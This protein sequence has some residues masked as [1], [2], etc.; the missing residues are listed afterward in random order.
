MC[1]EQPR[2]ARAMAAARPFGPEPTTTASSGELIP[3]LYGLELNVRGDRVRVRVGQPIKDVRDVQR[4][5]GGEETPDR[6]EGV[7]EHELCRQGRQGDG[8]PECSECMI[9][10]DQ[11]RHRYDAEI[12][13]L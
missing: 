8:E 6:D 10:R 3:T 9:A 7:A 1:T 2:S 11:E 5:D 12:E 13:N 4:D